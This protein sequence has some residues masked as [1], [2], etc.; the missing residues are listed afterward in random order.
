VIV[1][2]LGVVWPAI[3]AFAAFKTDI[4]GVKPEE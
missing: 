3:M 1:V 4:T 2:L